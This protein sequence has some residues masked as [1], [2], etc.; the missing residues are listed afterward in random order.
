MQVKTSYYR[1]AYGWAGL[2]L[3]ELG[4][5]GV[6]RIIT[7]RREARHGLATC[8]SVHLRRGAILEHR[9]GVDYSAVIAVSNPPRITEARVTE[10]HERALENLHTIRAKV[11]QFYLQQAAQGA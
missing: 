3:I 5:N 1:D 8:A 10:Q 2:S 11:E 7:E 9:L 6:L 4:N